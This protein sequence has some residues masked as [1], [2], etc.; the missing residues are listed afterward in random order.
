MWLAACSNKDCQWHHCTVSPISAEACADW[1]KSE[2]YRVDCRTVY[3][4]EIP[5]EPPPASST[6]AASINA[7]NSA[8]RHA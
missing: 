2:R 4:V 7:L 8:L 6:R 1:H 3:V 5:D